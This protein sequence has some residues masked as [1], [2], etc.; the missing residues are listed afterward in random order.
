LNPSPLFP[1][2][3]PCSYPP[4]KKF[5]KSGRSTGLAFIGYSSEEHA[6]Q[7]KEA[8][9]GAL[10]KGESNLLS[11]YAQQADA[12]LVNSSLVIR[13]KH[14]SRIRFPARANSSRSR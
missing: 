11:P 12:D 8:F 2:F 7:A 14:S 10:A 13:S 4:T 6:Q 3:A 1:L 9:D 5:D